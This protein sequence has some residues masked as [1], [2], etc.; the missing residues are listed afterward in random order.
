MRPQ[1]RPFAVEVKSKR[2]LPLSNAAIWPSD[3]PYLDYLP[4]RDVCEDVEVASGRGSPAAVKLKGWGGQPE[5]RSSPFGISRK[6][7][8]CLRTGTSATGDNLVE[9]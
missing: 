8:C 2:K 4:A 1:R 9:P 3:Q 7:I 5:R 6:G